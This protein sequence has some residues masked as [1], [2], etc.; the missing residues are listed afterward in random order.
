MVLA[1]LAA[2]V[3]L[4][5][6]QFCDGRVFR[7]KPEFCSGQADFGQAGPN[8]RLAGDERRTAGRTTLLAVPVS[9]QRAFFGNA[10]NV[11]GL[12]AHDAVVVGAHIEP[13]NVITPYD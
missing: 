7:L 11:G 4:W 1:K 10:V 6:Q 5:F 9:E 12:I 2:Y 3:S 8:R 13:A